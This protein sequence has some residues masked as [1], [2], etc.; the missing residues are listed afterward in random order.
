MIEGGMVTELN[1]DGKNVTDL[2]PVH[3]LV[4]LKVFRCTNGRP[5]IKLH[6]QSD[7]DHCWVNDQ[8]V[9]LGPTQSEE[10]HRA[11]VRLLTKLS[12]GRPASPHRVRVPPTVPEVLATWLVAQEGR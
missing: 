1:I 9:Y 12:S 8:W 5:P 3:F 11:Y 10:A 6:K 2:S 4:G 7:R